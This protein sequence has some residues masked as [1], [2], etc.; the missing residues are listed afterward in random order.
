MTDNSTT[1][2]TGQQPGMRGESVSADTYQ[3]F[4]DD[5]ENPWRKPDVKAF[6]GNISDATLWRRV[7]KGQIHRPLRLSR[8]LSIWSPKRC[9]KGRAKMLARA[10]EKMRGGDELSTG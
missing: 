2:P 5:D 10:A 9:R 3:D 1:P 6:F 7:Q 8:S 4:L